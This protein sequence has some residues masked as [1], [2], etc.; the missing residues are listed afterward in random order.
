[1]N[2]LAARHFYENLNTPE[3]AAARAYLIEKRKLTRATCIRFGLGY[4]KNSFTDLTDFLVSKGFTPEEIKENF[5][6]G[7]SQK[8]G[9]PFD[10]FRN[11]VIFPIIDTTGNI[12]AFG[13]RVMDDSKPKY[14]NS[15][16]TVVFKKSRN[17]F[18]LNFAKNAVLGDKQNTDNGS[19]QTTSYAV[20]AN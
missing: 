9:R 20:R 1:M 13:G 2:K 6:C 15:S 12:I 11:R 17:L 19:L 10:M 14:L 4:A 5:L 18:A 8:N 16:D 7:F 3:G